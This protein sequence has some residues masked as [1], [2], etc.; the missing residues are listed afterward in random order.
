M[1]MLQSRLQRLE[2]GPRRVLLAGA[3][4]GRT[5]WVGGVKALVDGELGAEEL[6]RCLREVT[7]LEVVERQATS[8]F[9]GKAEYRFRHELVRDAAYG[10][11]PDRLK[12]ISHRQAG[13]WLEQAGEQ[14]PL[15]LAGHYHLGQDTQKAV[16]FF[17]RAAER[18]VER[19]DLQGAQRCLALALTCEPTGELLV[20]LQ[21]LETVTCFWMED[22]EHA[23]ELGMRVRPELRPGSTAWGRVMGIL[24]L[25]GA[26]R[27]WHAELWV[28]RQIFLATTPDPDATSSYAQAAGFMA[29]MHIWAGDVAEAAEVLERMDQLCSGVAGRDG[30]SRGWLFCAR[31][32]FEHY[33][34]AR[35]WR[36]RQWAEQGTQAFLEVSR[37]SDMTAPQA[38]WGLTL[39]ALGEVPQALEVM[40]QCLENAQQA[41]LVYPIHYTQMHLVLVLVSSTEPV[42]LEEARQL[43]LSTVE[44]EK[45]NLM[46]LGTAH[47]ALARLSELQGQLTEAEAQARKACEVLELFLPYRVMAH[48]RLS[49]VLRAQK[50]LVEARGEAELG[51]RAMEQMGGAGAVSVGA[52]LALAEACFAQQ[53]R[54]PGERALREALRCVHQRAE[55]IPDAAARE[56]F[57]SQVPENAR[58]R[59]LARELW[60]PH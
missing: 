5:F 32:F 12:P 3:I 43:A 9:P 40:H 24:I 18:L 23:Y 19:R 33:H 57:L 20:E 59:E 39:A 6:E 42:H 54:A 26:Q 34:Q 47:L 50:R 13:A 21:A 28:L 10:L 22:F 17:T 44:T 2:A 15:V 16:R 56:R 49:T 11:V 48:T 14:D 58:T 51:V 60:G 45:V 38:L 37:G 46:R 7:E 41:G 30:T 4:F 1:A 55:E 52:W 27:G 8:H 35:P 29:C 31:G 36:S 53:A 25:V